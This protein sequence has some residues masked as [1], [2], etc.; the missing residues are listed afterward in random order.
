M[1]SSNIKSVRNKQGYSL[2]ELSI[3]I[4][5]IAIILSLLYQYY[6]RVKQ[7]QQRVAKSFNT[8]YIDDSIVGFSYAQ[9]RLPFPDTDNDGVENLGA[10]RGTVPE[11]TL[12]MAEKP[13]NKLNIP[14][15]YSIFSKPVTDPLLNYNDAD[16]G[17]GK[18]R[19][20][21][22]LPNGVRS[23]A[24]LYLGQTNT[25]DFCFA[26]RTAANITIN[27]GTVLYVSDRRAPLY[28]RNVAY[29]LVDPGSLDADGDGDL[30]D[31]F[32]SETTTPLQ[33]F[34]VASR[35]QSPTYD[36]RVNS[37]EFSEIFGSLAC[38]SVISAALHAHDNAVL[39]ADMMKTSFDDYSN[40]LDL[41]GQLAEADVAL[42]AAAVL[43]A[44]A[45][46]ADVVAAAA[47]ALAES[48]TPPFTA[49]GVPAMVE[50][51]ISAVIAV[52]ATVAAGVTTGFAADAL[53]KINKAINCFDNGAQCAVGTGIFV[54][55]ASDLTDDIRRHAV[56]ADA[57]GL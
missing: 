23:A 52:A 19:L 34:E 1:I 27:D 3:V 36:D 40:L 28:N 17:R 32:N 2:V 54:Q 45:G 16:L 20:R 41:T 15:E 35:P 6:P 25:I 12:G 24:Q 39:A 10:L 51:A 13:V 47:T 5:I 9:G 44:I 37:M 53:I 21:A 56:A 57:A 29:V 22:L 14:I 26:L 4:L 55:K 18:D 11:I 48:L 8:E 46:D 50:I 31:G 30:L 7:V 33:R 38:G 49:I 42:A 43:Q